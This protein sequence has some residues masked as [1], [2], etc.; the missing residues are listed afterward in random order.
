MKLQISKNLLFIFSVFIILILIILFIPLNVLEFLSLEI[1]GEPPI[2]GKSWL[3]GVDALGG[4]LSIRILAI[5]GVLIIVSCLPFVFNWKKTE[6]A[7]RQV[8]RS[9]IIFFLS[10]TAIFFAINI[11]IGYNWWDPKAFLGMGPLFFPSMISL[12]ILGILPEINLKLFKFQ[13]SDFADSTNNLK[14]SSLIMLIISFGYGL[15]SLIWHCC[16]FYNGTMYFFFFIIKFIQLWAIMSFFYKWGLK[17]FLNLMQEWQAYILISILFGICYPWHTMGFAIT[18][19]FF[20]FIICYLTRKTNSYLL[21]LILL[22]FS[23]IFH[24]GL[25]WNGGFITIFIIFPISIFLMVL[26][27]F[28]D[29]KREKIFKLKKTKIVA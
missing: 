6:L 5:L 25:A 20:G 29:V 21:G 7:K 1:I 18:F 12:I 9:E 10:S 3:E 26:L 24:A 23:Y 2:N 16:S 28:F 4:A 13:R 8:K 22:Y 17:I 19:S 11:L 14:E 27:I 15:I